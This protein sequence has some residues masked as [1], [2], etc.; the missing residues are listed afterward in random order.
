LL[1]KTDLYYLS[2]SEKSTPLS[3]KKRLLRR[4]PASVLKVGG[5]FVH[6]GDGGKKAKRGT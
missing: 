4:I 6:K 1:E 3:R 2:G 5:I